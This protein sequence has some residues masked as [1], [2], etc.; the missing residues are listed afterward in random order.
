[1]RTSRHLQRGGIAFPLLIA[2]FLIGVASLIYGVTATNAQPDFALF[3]VSF[4]FLLGISQAGVVFTAI[5]RLVKSDWGKPWYRLAELSTLAY[6]PFAIVGYL[7]I[8][9]FAKDDL[10]YW[11]Q[12]TPEDHISPYLD[13]NW[14]IIRDLGGLLLF[15]VLA[16]IYARKAWRPDLAGKGAANANHDEVEK[17]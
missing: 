12:A 5:L 14:L 4:L 15:Y 11:L 10:F 6:F 2:I 3:T 8:V 7:L 16:V 9:Y 17:D 1:M 13:I